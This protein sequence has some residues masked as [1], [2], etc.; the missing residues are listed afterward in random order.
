[1][2]AFWKGKK[3]SKLSNCNNLKVGRSKM[4]FL[5]IE[6]KSTNVWIVQEDKMYFSLKKGSLK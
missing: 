3:K 5:N 1:M 6:V 4:S 2:G